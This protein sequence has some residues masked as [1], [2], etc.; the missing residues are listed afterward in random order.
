VLLP[1]WFSKT[2]VKVPLFLCPSFN[3]YSPAAAISPARDLR[4]ARAMQDEKA[5]RKARNQ[6]RAIFDMYDA[7]TI[8]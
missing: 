1:L 5:A 6:L 2:Q 8:C 3:S 7:K 4:E